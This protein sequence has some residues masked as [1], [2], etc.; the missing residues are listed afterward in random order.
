MLH[1][2]YLRAAKKL[3]RGIAKKDLLTAENRK[4]I[5]DNRYLAVHYSLF[6]RFLIAQQGRCNAQ[7]CFLPFSF[8]I[9]HPVSAIL[10]LKQLNGFN[11]FRQSGLLEQISFLT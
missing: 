3:L 5:I 9:F 7:F 1:E 2:E 6:L 11:I 4:H 10:V 8:G